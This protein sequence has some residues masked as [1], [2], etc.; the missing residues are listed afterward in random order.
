MTK[1]IARREL[2]R[3]TAVA[4]GGVASGV[5]P[6]HFVAAASDQDA[7]RKTR[8]YNSD[9][10]YRRLGSTGLWVSAVCLGGHFKRVGEILGHKIG[11]Y[12]TPP[13]D[14]AAMA[15]LQ[16][17]RDEVL[18][19]CMEVG[20]N[21]VDACTSG[22]GS[23]YGPALKGRRDQMYMGFSQAPEYCPRSKKYRKADALLKALEGSLKQCQVDYFD[24]WRLTAS[25]SGQH[26][27]AEEEQFVEALDKAKK[28]G[29]ARFGGV[30]SHNRT[31]LKRLAETY[32][33]HFQVMLTPYTAKTRELPKDSLFEAVRKH[34]IGTFGIKPFGSNSL[35]HGATSAEEKSH[36]ARLTIR[37]IL[38]NPGITAPIPGL[39]CVEE[40]DNMA[41]A[42]KE[43]R[44]LSRAEEVELE[45]ISEHMWANLPSHYAWLRNWEYV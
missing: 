17:N 36:R 23:I 45:Q 3:N 13:E 4:A 7:I 5:I 32:P 1:G 28:Q 38:G 10:E 19:R 31:W 2:L 16:K 6:G 15:A 35:F 18:T 12:K 33:K 25:S 44:K 8:S 40:V 26:T 34:D 37:Y 21:Y 11:S 41:L 14:K 24:I 20:I 29:K 22:E 30:S 27:P 39:A 43:V 42:I 9:M